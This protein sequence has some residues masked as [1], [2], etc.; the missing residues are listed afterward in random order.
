[1]VS[2]GISFAFCVAL[3]SSAQEPLPQVVVLAQGDKM[4]C[5][6]SAGCVAFTREA[7]EAL[8]KQVRQESCRRSI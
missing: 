5:L 2:K 3:L 7:F 1:M 6:Q 4:Q 8:V